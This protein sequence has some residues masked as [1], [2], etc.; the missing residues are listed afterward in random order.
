MS[1]YQVSSFKSAKLCGLTICQCIIIFVTFVATCPPPGDPP[2]PTE[3]PPNTASSRE[4]T[5]EPTT[6]VVTKKVPMSLNIVNLRTEPEKLDEAGHAWVMICQGDSDPF[7]ECCISNNLWELEHLPRQNGIIS[8]HK[9]ES[10]LSS[11]IKLEV[12]NNLVSV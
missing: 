12:T 6:I 9:R 2:D 10:S 4:V 3:Y 8:F 7:G 1:N 11:S 5:D